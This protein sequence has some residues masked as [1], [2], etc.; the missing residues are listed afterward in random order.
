VPEQPAVLRRYLASWLALAELAHASLVGGD[1]EVPHGR[2]PHGDPP[3]L[4]TRSLLLDPARWF[5]EE[6]ENLCQTAVLAAR[7]VSTRRAGNSC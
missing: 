7:S 3:E 4:V 1:V 2:V 5:R 6:R